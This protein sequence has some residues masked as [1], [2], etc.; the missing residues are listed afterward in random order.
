MAC[1]RQTLTNTGT[2]QINFNYRRCDNS[3]WEYQVKLMPNKSKNIWYIDNTFNISP[4][5]D[6]N[7]SITDTIPF[8][9]V[10]KPTVCNCNSYTVYNN[11]LLGPTTVTFYDC[12]KNLQRNIV[13]PNTGISFCACNG[14]VTADGGSSNIINSGPC[15]D[16]PS[17]TPTPTK[18][19]TPT[20]TKTKTPTPTKTSTP[21]PTKTSTPTPTNTKTSTPT[22]TQTNTQTPTHTTTPTVTQTPTVTI[23][24]SVTATP[25]YTTTPT[26]T[27]TPCECRE[28][29]WTGTQH[30]IDLATGNNP[31]NN[32]YAVYLEYDLCQPSC[33]GPGSG[34]W[35]NGGSTLGFVA[36]VTWCQ[37]MTGNTHTPDGPYIYINDV[38]TYTG[39]TSTWT[40]TSKCC[41]GTTQ[42]LEYGYS[43]MQSQG[44]PPSPPYYNGEVVFYNNLVTYNPNSLT[45]FSL[46][47]IDLWD[48]NT[49]QCTAI[50][51]ISGLTT[52]GGEIYFNQFGN[53]V[54]FSGT[55]SSF[56]EN[57]TGFSGSNLTIIQSATTTFSA[58]SSIDVWYNVYPSSFQGTTGLT[59]SNSCN[60]WTGDPSSKITIYYS[61]SGSIIDSTTSL[62]LNSNLTIPVPNGAFVS[63]G[64]KSYNVGL[65]GLVLNTFNC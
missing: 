41:S 29:K 3:M 2:T 13:Y 45:G 61:P 23:T 24:S 17:P 37:P 26:P 49:N 31:P 58:S 47:L 43:F 32:N 10:P 33:G 56:T 59:S 60:A 19:I 21:T 34:S 57:T 16:V 55:S 52:N 12:G 50:P 8:P 62:Y 39:L 36:T 11:S 20:P 54:G 7:I 46:N 1:N 14:T 64:T 30:D 5:F 15:G 63:N 35:R 27:E 6:S 28:Y 18:T 38:K 9:T 40:A 51:E 48:N 4:S 65:G 22:Q 42:V 25:T 53:T 44:V